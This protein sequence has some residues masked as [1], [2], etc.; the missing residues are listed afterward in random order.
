MQGKETNNLWV[1]ALALCRL[2]HRIAS[3]LSSRKNQEN[4]FPF[5]LQIC[6]FSGW[7][8]SCLQ[9]LWRSTL[10]SGFSGWLWY[11]VVTCLRGVI[12]TCHVAAGARKWEPCWLLGEVV[13]W[14]ALNVLRGPLLPGFWALWTTMFLHS[15]SHPLLAEGQRDCSSSLNVLCP[16]DSVPSS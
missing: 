14:L 10:L 16:C 8:T 9:L 2:A 6:N 3:W 7:G 11:D 4:F 15:L 5:F 13:L 1:V 12:V